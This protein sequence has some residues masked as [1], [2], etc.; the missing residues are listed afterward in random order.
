MEKYLKTEILLNGMEKQ[1]S[2]ENVRTEMI[3]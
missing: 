2:T 3:I 1:N